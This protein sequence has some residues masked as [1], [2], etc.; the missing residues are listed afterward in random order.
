[1]LRIIGGILAGI[2]T[3]FVAVFAIEW[4]GHQFFPI[5]AEVNVRDPAANPTL[6]TGAPLGAQLFVVAAWFGGALLGGLVAGRISD[7]HWAAWTIVALVVLAAIANIAM[8]PHPVWMQIGAVVAPLLGGFVAS[9]LM[10]EAGWRP[11]SR[12]D[13]V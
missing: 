5:S 13:A 2:V 6:V 11:R 1:M 7:R 12:A 4:I 10:P 3:L 8:I 9:R